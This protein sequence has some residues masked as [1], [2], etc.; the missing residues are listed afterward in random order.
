[1]GGPPVLVFT[2][3]GGSLGLPR[4]MGAVAGTAVV[5]VVAGWGRWVA[6]YRNFVRQ[7]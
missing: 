4:I 7:E 1:M 2:G 3:V 5:A 6:G